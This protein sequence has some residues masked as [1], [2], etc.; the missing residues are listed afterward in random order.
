MNGTTF[1]RY[2]TLPFATTSWSFAGAGDFDGDGNT[3]ILL[4]NTQT[5]QRLIWIM[6]GTVFSTYV[7]I[8]S[9]TTDWSICNF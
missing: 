9:A 1:I 7:M 2:V 5:G 6:H 4:Q 8:P 3:D